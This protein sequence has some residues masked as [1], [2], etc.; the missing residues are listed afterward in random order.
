M[1]RLLIVFVLLL[2]YSVKSH[3][4]E[5]QSTYDWSGIYLGGTLGYGQG[6]IEWLDA[7]G[8]DIPFFGAPGV[9]VHHWPSGITYGGVFGYNWQKD[10]LV[11]GIEASIIGN[12]D[13][14]GSYFNGTRNLP[15]SSAISSTLMFG[16]RV[17]YAKD[18]SLYYF[19]SGIASAD[20]DLMHLIPLGVAESSV[21]HKG[22]YLGGGIDWA[23]NSNWVFG[24]GYKHIKF[25]SKVHGGYL[26][27]QTTGVKIDNLLLDTVLMRLTYKF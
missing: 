1:F 14:K 9:Q 11:F 27:A 18:T 15:N 23:L 21:T 13:D 24:V 17:G 26:G 12:V 25:Q 19:Q 20:I 5:Q 2:S 7:N 16:G 10:S 4:Q 22:Y 6:N 8:V 3:S